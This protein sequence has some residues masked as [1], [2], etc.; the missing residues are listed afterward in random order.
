MNHR[1]LFAVAR[2][3]IPKDLLARSGK[4]FYSGRRSFQNQTSLYILGVNPGGDPEDLAEET[5]SNHTD[6]V[7]NIAPPD[8]SAYRDEIWKRKAPG[9]HGMQPRLLHMFKMLGLNPGTVPASNLVFVRSRRTGHLADDFTGLANLCWPFHECVIENLKPKTILC[10][11]HVAGD[12]VC[13]RVG[14]HERY[15]TFVE[16][17]K[18]G[19]KSH[20]YRSTTGTK[21][22]VAT[23]PS[24]ANWAAIQTDPTPLIV[25]ALRD[26]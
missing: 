1:D 22:I 23:H 6:C 20:A 21:V 11:G 8:W 3:A 7:A 18:R 26:A 13:A 25:S 14:A 24:I 10:L 19:W 5:I 4:V 15:D 12:Y 9:K 2:A 16:K 17:N